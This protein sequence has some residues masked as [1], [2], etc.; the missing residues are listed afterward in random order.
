MRSISDRADDS[1]HL[2]F[3]RFVRSIASRYALHTISSLVQQMAR[4]A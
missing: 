4:R 3:P 2:D 1:A